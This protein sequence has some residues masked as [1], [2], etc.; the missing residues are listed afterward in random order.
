MSTA[1]PGGHR[2]VPCAFNFIQRKNP[3]SLF[4]SGY[5]HANII[6]QKLLNL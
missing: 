5:G 6:T 4:N 3:Q 2:T 1:F